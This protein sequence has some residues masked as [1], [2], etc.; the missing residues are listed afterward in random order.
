MAYMKDV[1]GRRLD[2]IEVLDT[3]NAVTKTDLGR[4]FASD[5]TGIIAQKA[6]QPDFAKPLAA[7]I[8]VAD[9]DEM[10]SLYWPWMIRMDGIL[11]T[12]I[13]TYYLY[14]STD[15]AGVDGYIGLYTA[16]SPTGPFTYYGQVFK[17][18]HSGNETETP[19]V[20]WVPESGLFHMYY[21]QVASTGHL[22]AQTTNVATS[23][24]GITWTRIGIAVDVSDTTTWPAPSHTGYFNPLRIGGKWLGIG[25]LTGETQSRWCLAYSADGIAWDIDP[26]PLGFGAEYLADGV[27]R[28]EWNSSHVINWRGQLYWIGV[29]SSF[30]NGA[31][32]RTGRWCMAPLAPDLRKLT[33]P[34]RQIIEE[35]EAWENDYFTFGSVFLD[36]D[37]Q[38]YIYYR[39]GYPTTG[40]GVVKASVSL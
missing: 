13:D 14:I 22:A 20:V 36:N 27:E 12:P 29:I 24:D 17:D 38:F 35:T 37:G 3:S 28:I 39:S 30:A 33:G 21:Q 34:P 10:P 19:A 2:S 25:L 23:P 4:N 18:T 15:H 11:E 32:Y 5:F 26:R 8:I 1:T 40:V 16:P 9:V 6:G 7:P 31:G